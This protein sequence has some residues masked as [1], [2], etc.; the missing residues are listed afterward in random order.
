[1]TARRI[2]TA[3][4]ALAVLWALGCA[5]GLTCGTMDFGSAAWQIAACMVVVDA[6]ERARRKA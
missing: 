4:T 3:I 1:M 6:M 2:R 5:G